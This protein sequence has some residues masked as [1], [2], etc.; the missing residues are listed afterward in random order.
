MAALADNALAFD[1]ETFLAQEQAKDLLRFTTA[2]SVDDGKSTLI[3]RLLYDSQNVYED[4]LKAVTKAS[5][6]RSAGPIDF[7]LLTDGL[8]AEREQGITIDVAYRYFATAR[9][10]FIIADTPGHEQYTRNMATGAS[11]AELAIILIDARNGILPQ[12]R[13]HAYIASL[14]GIPNFAIAVNKM[15]LVEYDQAVF[16]AIERDFREFLGRLHARPHVYFLPIS[17]LEGD[18]VVRR[19][20]K[21]PWFEGPSLLE[22]LETVPVLDRVRAAAF[23]FPVQRVVRPDQ[24][25]RGYAGQVVSGAVRPGDAIVAFPSGQ[26][27]RVE[28]I[29]TFDG[30]LQE[31]IAPMSVTLT[32]EDELDISRGDMI[33]PAQK[34]PEVARQF[35]ANV[36]WLNEQPLDPAKTYVVKHTAQN[37]AAEVKAIKHRVN[38]T[39]LEHEAADRLEMNAIGVL[40][41]ET[42]RPIYFDAYSENRGT[43]SFILLDPATNATVGAGM[44]LWAVQADRARRNVELG[45]GRVTAAE[46]IARYRHSGATVALGHREQLAWLLERKLFDRGC[47]VVISSNAGVD[48][49]ATGLLV[50]HLSDEASDLPIDDARAA[51]EVIRRL[52]E[53]GV[54]LPDESLTGG[55][56]I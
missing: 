29:E 47:A 30:P 12:S 23:R 25:F 43:G 4:Q 17:A 24:T 16:R 56:G 19:S 49:Y 14:L 2:G 15:D 10:K 38:I 13:R 1:I 8:R 6:N 37:V 52:E 40:R 36:V 31:A 33:A 7:S 39:T 26:R 35:D 27:S 28:S 54:L 3:G 9:R 48:A 50:L 34:L 44:I 5:V 21:M 51:E 11:T 20:R 53:S 42:S 46:R 55:E 18:N 22:F 41:I 32:L 45:T